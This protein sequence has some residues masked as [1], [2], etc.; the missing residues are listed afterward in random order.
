M[1]IGVRLKEIRE[2]VGCERL[3]PIV[4]SPCEDEFQRPRSLGGIRSSWRRVPDVMVGADGRVGKK[5]QP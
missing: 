2:S 5:R 3:A 1:V 4:A